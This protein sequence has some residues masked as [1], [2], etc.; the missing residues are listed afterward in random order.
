MRPFRSLHSK[1]SHRLWT[2]WFCS[3]F[4]E[5]DL[6]F[7]RNGHHCPLTFN[8][9]DFIIG[10]LSRTTSEKGGNSTASQ[11]CDA[12]QASRHDEAPAASTIAAIAGEDPKYDRKKPFWICTVYWLLQRNWLIATR[13]PAI[14]NLRMFQKFVSMQCKNHLEEQKVF[15][16][17]VSRQCQSSLVCVSMERPKS[18]KLAYNRFKGHCLQ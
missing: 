5:Y 17:M 18:T 11:L 13:D 10:I 1:C 16:F 9:A 3:K 7:L 6:T 2:I 8:P 12:F 4:A 14:Q 15:K